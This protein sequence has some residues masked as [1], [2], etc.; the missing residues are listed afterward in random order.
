[1]NWDPSVLDHD[2]DDDIQWYDALTDE[3]PEI[4]RM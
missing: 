2:A 4:G 3:P 1:M